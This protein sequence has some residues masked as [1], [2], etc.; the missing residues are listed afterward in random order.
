METWLAI[1]AIAVTCVFFVWILTRQAAQERNGTLHHPEDEQLRE[2]ADTRDAAT[3]TPEIP[4]RDGLA[5]PAQSP[6]AVAAPGA[7]TSTPELPEAPEDE[8]ETEAGAEGA[9]H[10]EGGTQTE[11]APTSGSKAGPTSGPGSEGGRTG[12]TRADASRTGA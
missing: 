9:E 10:A 2:D 1:A 8:T 4:W 12:S 11:A 7:V 5:P 6:P 3:S